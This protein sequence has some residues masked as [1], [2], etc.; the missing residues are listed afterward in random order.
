MNLIVTKI[1]NDGTGAFVDVSP[2]IYNDGGD[3]KSLTMEV[4]A[5]IDQYTSYT[6]SDDLGI[7]KGTSGVRGKVSFDIPRNR[8]YT[9]TVNVMENGKIAASGSVSN[10]IKLNELKYN[11][12]V[13]FIL[14]EEGK[15]VTAAATMAPGA[16]KQPGFEIAFALIS[17]LIVYS[18]R[19][20]IRIKR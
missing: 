17:V 8:E 2:A 3:S 19:T 13:T 5:R 4:T 7:V 16:S 1:Y 14:V 12:P 15:P 18:I 9:F 6:K 20:I 11:T 10:K